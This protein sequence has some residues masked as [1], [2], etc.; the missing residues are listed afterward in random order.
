[1][2]STALKKA[3]IVGGVRTPFVKS[4]TKFNRL[5][6][7]QVMTETIKKLV[8]KFSLQG[9]LIGDVAFGS[10]MLNSGDWNLTREVVLGSG[11]DPRTP[12]YNVQRACGTG[13][14]TTWQIAS[15]IKLG[16]IEVGIAGG[17]DTNSDAPVMLSRNFTWNLFDLQNQKG[18]FNKLKG[19]FKFSVRDLKLDFPMVREPRT[20]LSMGEHT[21]LMVKHWK[22]TR[23]EQDQLAF[24]SHQKAAR[25]Y[26]DGFHQDLVFEYQGLT[27]D[28]LVR[29]DTSLEKLA[30]LKPAFDRTATGTLT[31]GNSTPL[32]DG[33]SAVLVASEEYAQKN[34]LPILAN[35]IDAEVAAVDFVGGEGLLMAPVTAVSRL[36]ARNNLTLQDFDFYE[37]HEAFAGQVLCNLKAWE[38][39]EYCEKVL[40]RSAPMG[41]IDRNK[42]NVKGGSLALG[43][44]FSATGGR[45]VASLGKILQQNGQ[46][47]GLISIC[48]AGGMGVAAILER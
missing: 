27:A 30:K 19:I 13:L 16:Q 10:V 2:N 29:A 23:A 38:S 18:F 40:G 4:F 36:L 17:S 1:M 6:N 24:E 5:T 21:E 37:I 20:G 8:E 14:E 39:A 26:A 22:I 43:H 44:P 25:A 12:G 45:I 11:L 48:T 31:A 3:V 32:T 47:R 34:N 33:A 35:F 15:K 46:G 7:Q 42:M 28:P 41:K 9:K